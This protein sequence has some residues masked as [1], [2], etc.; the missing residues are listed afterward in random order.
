MTGTLG[1]PRS[2]SRLGPGYRIAALTALGVAALACSEPGTTPGQVGPSVTV[3][4][5][6]V[7]VTLAIDRDSVTPGGMVAL[8]VSIRN[9]TRTGIIWRSNGCTL[10]AP[11]SVQAVGPE[12]P[13]PDPVEPAARGPL[14]VIRERLISGADDTRPVAEVRSAET[15]RP[16]S[17]AIDH[18]FSELAAGAGLVYDGTWTARTVRGAPALP[19][20]YIVRA[21]FTRL[22]PGVPLVPAAYRAERDGQTIRAE[23]TLRL[24]LPEG[25]AAGLSAADAVDRLLAHPQIAEH[26]SRPGAAEST[27]LRYDEGSW[28][29]RVHAGPDAVLV[30]V[31][32]DRTDAAATVRVEAAPP[33]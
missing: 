26:L 8:R 27:S 4:D 5:D 24:V 6:G 31:V 10:Q 28:V 12:R 18:G 25:G 3:E 29:L 2:R 17:C 14:G 7:T 15:G 9:G 11:A 22:R 30:A 13:A 1:A 20:Q 19:G 16:G 32:A 21:E 33:P 23:L